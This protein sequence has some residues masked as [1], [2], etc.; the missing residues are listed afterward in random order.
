MKDFVKLSE[1][2][3]IHTFVR[4]TIDNVN[5][6]KIK[7]YDKKRKDQRQFYTRS[8]HF[9][10]ECGYLSLCLVILKYLMSIYVNSFLIFCMLT[11]IFYNFWIVD[12][13][14]SLRFQLKWPPLKTLISCIKT[15]LSIQIRNSICWIN[16][17]E[18]DTTFLRKSISTF[19]IILTEELFKSQVQLWHI[20]AQVDFYCQ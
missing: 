16:K 10:N 2:L 3:L 7:R 19:S 12:P 11:F 18:K 1:L 15:R 13:T 9:V 8:T 14:V 17:S 5:I 6:T 4:T 20:I